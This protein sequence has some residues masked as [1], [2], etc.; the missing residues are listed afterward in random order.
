M[1]QRK[2]LVVGALSLGFLLGADSAW[3]QGVIEKVLLDNEAV[4]VS[5]L[6]FPPGFRGHA[7][8]A[9]VNEMAYV[10]EGEFTVISVPDGKRLLKSGDVDWAAKGTV[11]SSRNDSATPARVLVILFKER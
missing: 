2:W 1:R 6:I 4:K 11:H 8:P 9:P 5:E 10:L 7:H 3:A